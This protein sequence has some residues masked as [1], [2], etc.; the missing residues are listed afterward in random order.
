LAWLVAVPIHP[1]TLLAQTP[2]G[3]PTFRVD[4]I[5]TTPLPGLDLKLEQVPAPV[6]TAIGADVDASGALDVADFMNRRFTSVF[7]NEMQGNPFQPDLNY[8]G[9][10]ASPLLGT[11]QGLSVYMDGV[12]LNQPFGDVVSWD[13]IPRMAIGSTTLIPGSN[14]LF[15]L[16]TLGGALS[17]QT[18]DGRTS[19]GTSVRAIYGSDTRRALEFEHGGSRASGLHWYLAGNLFAE[20][21]WRE[22]SPSNVGQIFGKLGWHQSTGD[23]AL[24][25]GYANDSLTGNGLQEQRLLDRDYAS[26]Y[27]KPDKT[28]NRSTFLNLTTRQD[29]SRTM[30]LSGNVY[31]RHLHTNTLNGDINDDSLDQSVYQPSAAEIAS[32]T[33]AGYTGF[34][35]SGATAANTPVPSWRCIA[36]ILRNDEPGEKCT[37]LLNRGETGQDNY[38]LAGQ[39]TWR[40][41]QTTRNA[42]T[43]GA[44]YDGG[45]SSFQQSTQLG[46]L[47]L[48]RG[49]MGLNGFADGGVTGGNVDGVPYDNRVNLDGRVNTGSVF[50]SD[51]V[52]IGTAWA[53]TLSGRYN[54]TS[55][56]NTDG[57]TPAGGAGS[58]TGDHSF[59]RFNPAVGVTFSPTRTV[60]LYAGYSEGSR[61][62]TSIELGCADPTQPCKLPNALA[63]DPPLNQV[64]TRTWEAGVRGTQGSVTWNAGVFHADNRDDLLFVA[65]TQTGFGY[66]KN[67]GSTRRQ[68]LELGLNAHQGR[69]SGGVGYTLLDATFQSAETVDGTGNSTNDSAL[70]GAKGLEG[71]IEIQPGDRIPLIPRQMFKAFADLQ[72]TSK[73]S[74]DIDLI[75]ASGVYARG[76]ENNLSQPDGGI[77]LGPGTTPAYGIVNL[78]AH[79]Q[80]TKWIQLL[81]QINNLFD[82]H[83]FTASQLQPTGFNAAGTFIA[84]PFPAIAGEF[85]LQQ[86]AFYAPGAPTTYWVGTRFKF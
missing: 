75:A 33:A 7:V 31:Y 2:P 13:L 6:Q 37:G 43:V 10:T 1:S 50:A 32:L 30:T 38:G 40:A 48:D 86:A 85:P 55:V 41:G 78:G 19:P 72:I 47:T 17:L 76:N 25:V 79:Y 61:A 64:V 11:P 66:F 20:D 27:T 74:A 60:N 59:D 68:G 49:V 9:Y 28:D 5:E 54:R 70:Q 29:R 84:R 67:F 46:Y 57:L 63:G 56:S 81:A 80:V 58:L 45:R 34:P 71:T 23:T 69:F 16:N 83:Y 53:V 51:V 65:S 18:K 82:R 44:G 35:T 4:V 8:R 22:D 36:N 42:L 39:L 77:Y 52:S 15:G 62:P 12:R 24:S 3:S 26:V 14:P 73:L 21:G